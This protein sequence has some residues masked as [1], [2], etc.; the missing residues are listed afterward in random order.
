MSHERA[1]KAYEFLR[2]NDGQTIVVSDLVGASGWSESTVRTYLT[3]HWR[4]WLRRTATGDYRI[5][6][7]GQVSF[8][9]FLARQSQVKAAPGV[10]ASL[11]ERIELA[12][13]TMESQEFEFK[14]DLPSNRSRLAREFAA[15]ATSND[16][17][18][19]LGVTDGGMV[20][21]LAGAASTE[22]QA[23]IREEIESAA[24]KLRPRIA[25][26]TTFV[27]FNDVWIA[28]VEV[29]KGPEPVY[30]SDGRPYVRSGSRSRPADPSEVKSLVSDSIAARDRNLAALLEELRREIRDA[31][32]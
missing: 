14:E 7:F 20:A 26:T 28:A 2:R 4:P 9:S 15:F 17:L 12:L 27:E 23:R 5:R 22:R 11:R 19:L 3:K 32:G 24:D 29:T 16:G 1:R 25:V 8:S 13:R 18:I 6:E 10:P 30:Y 31:R 21:G